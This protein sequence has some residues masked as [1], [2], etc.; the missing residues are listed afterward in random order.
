MKPI[1][2]AA[3]KSGN[4]NLSNPQK[5]SDLEAQAKVSDLPLAPCLDKPSVLDMEHRDDNSFTPLK[6]KWSVFRDERAKMKLPKQTN[7]AVNNDPK[8][9]ALHQ[10]KIP[11]LGTKEPT[12]QPNPTST[13]TEAKTT[14][15]TTI[16]TSPAT[17]VKTIATQA[18][19]SSNFKQRVQPFQAHYLNKNYQNDY[20][21]QASKLYMNPTMRLS[22]AA[23][24]E[25]YYADQYYAEKYYDHVYADHVYNRTRSMHRSAYSAYEEE[26]IR[27]NQY[28]ERYYQRAQAMQANQSYYYDDPMER[29]NY[30]SLSSSNLY[31]KRCEQHLPDVHDYNR[32]LYPPRL[33]QRDIPKQHIEPLQP[34]RLVNY[35]SNEIPNRESYRP[36]TEEYAERH[37]QMQNAEQPQTSSSERSSKTESRLQTKMDRIVR[38]AFEGRK[39]RTLR[40]LVSRTNLSKNNLRKTLQRVAIKK[41]SKWR[42]SK[43]YLD[44]YNAEIT[45]ETREYSNHEP[46]ALNSDYRK[47][48]KCYNGLKFL[49]MDSLVAKSGL[50]E[51]KLRGV[52]KM[53]GKKRSTKWRLENYRKPLIH[54]HRGHKS[55]ERDD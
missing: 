52:L 26:C 47:V 41:D 31:P 33:V 54:L 45:G 19:S 44:A 27:Y 50:R 36:M 24:A 28:Y 13:S 5:I 16:K 55:K 40:D 43:F 38:S 25:Q 12:E 2:E 17:A 46:L 23:Y 10:F 11:K 29:N 51:S 15:T 30:P 4:V 53:I 3:K 35:I 21:T 22:Q 42:I 37:I 39:Y 18:T 14:T 7:E 49:R 32:S 9:N 20:P 48:I 8:L 6:R 1:F 34:N